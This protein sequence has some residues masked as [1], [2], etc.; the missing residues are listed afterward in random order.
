MSQKVKS[1]VTSRMKRGEY[2]GPFG[3][4]GYKKD[5][6]NIHKLV[7]DDEAAQVVRRIFD[8]VIVGVKRGEIAK[9]LNAEGVPMPA[10]YKKKKGCTRDWYPDG[11]KAGWN[12]SMIAK[13]I[14]DERY[15]GNM[16]A[17]KKDMKL[18]TQNIR[19]V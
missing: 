19:L 6:D 4:Y 14:R 10:V 5:P 11:K 16:V 3:F 8:M 13:I 17:H 9:I 1:A 12:N 18:S 7:I 15:A 2:L